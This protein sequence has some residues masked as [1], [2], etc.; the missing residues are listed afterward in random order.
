MAYTSMKK[1]ILNE[2][3]KYNAGV[4]TAEEYTVWKENAQNKLDI[5]LACNRLTDKQYEELTGMILIM[6]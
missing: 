6:E 3:N 5:F 2:N 4:I 1:L